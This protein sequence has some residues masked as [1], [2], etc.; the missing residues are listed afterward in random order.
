MRHYAQSLTVMGRVVSIDPAEHGFEV[1]TRSGDRYQAFVNVETSYQGIQNLDGLNLDRFLPMDVP[2]LPATGQAD[3]A[4]QIQ[5]YIRKN[6]LICLDGIYQEDGP[7]RRLEVRLVHLL[8]M[9]GEPDDYLF[10]STHW[11]LTQIDRFANQWLEE[12]FGYK[13]TYDLDDFSL[14]YKTN[15]SIEGKPTDD[16]RQEM[17]TLSRLIYGLSSAYLLTGSE[18]YLRAARAAVSFQRATFRYLTHD[19]RY[20]FW[21][22]G[23]DPG[24]DGSR[25]IIPSQNDDDLNTIPLYEQIYAI[26][27]LAQFHR[28]TSNWEVLEDIRRTVRTF[29]TFYLDRATQ[30]NG[31]PGLGGYF[32]HLDYATMRPDVPA[33]G[34]NQSRKNWNSTGDHI[35]AY[36]INVILALDPLPKDAGDD[37]KTFLN[38]CV[39]LLETTS[40][41]ILEKFPDPESNYVN[42]RF[43]YNWKPDHSW[44]WQQNRAICGHNC[45]IAWNLTRVAKFFL[46]RDQRNRH[47]HSQRMRSE[48]D[49]R[50]AMALITYAKKLAQSM[51]EYGIDQV[52]GGLYDAV[53]RNPSN[54]QPVEFAWMNTKDFWQQEQA[55]LAFLIVHS[56]SRKD[57][58]IDPS[59]TYGAGAVDRGLK[60]DLLAL[61]RETEAFWNIYFLDHDTRGVYQRVTASGIP[62]ETGNYGHKAGH[63]TGYHV[64]ELNYLAH[65]YNRVFVTNGGE[66]S[67]HN[68]FSLYFRPERGNRQLSINVLPDFFAPGEIEVIRVSVR[69]I[70]RPDLA[71][72]ARNY[73]S[74]TPF[75]I[76]LRDEELGSEVIVEF[77]GH[78][79]EIKPD[80]AIVD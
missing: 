39:T 22:Y 21:A 64:E 49:R 15:L 50:F 52:C 32:S 54:N 70:D 3:P 56:V 71:A 10:E 7:N 18:R 44:G 26:C 20:C 4:A 29:N 19:G 35:P 65:I 58:P 62:Y 42:E 9:S 17:A 34:K 78:Q 14:S 59:R 13:M 67:S 27:G 12:L 8:S 74:P 69:G 31:Y 23:R 37:M 73:D 5:K 80:G 57:E 68:N 38:E 77:R 79:I 30:R 66:S 47:D 25:L 48:G 75:Q 41:L 1:Q 76:E 11:W 61:A 2:T 43:H 28:I 36:L 55:I 46:S 60:A 16:P 33:L 72:K 53:Q 24:R 51:A 6:S 45:K 63:S 40:R